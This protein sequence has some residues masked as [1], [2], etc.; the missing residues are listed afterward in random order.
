ME[1]G[2][3]LATN[4][5]K[6]LHILW[7]VFNHRLSMKIL[8]Q[9]KAGGFAFKELL[10]ALLVLGLIALVAV[11][12]LYKEREKAQRISCVG[13]L[14]NIGLSFRIWATDNQNLFPMQKL[15]NLTA[16]A[17]SLVPTFLEL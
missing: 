2:T 17:A 12:R 14:K 9:G 4:C 1:V 16:S 5:A 13:R 7:L 8:R 15:T 10:C 11:P 6:V 3:R